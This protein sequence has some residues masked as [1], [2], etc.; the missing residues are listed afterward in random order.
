MK[1][2]IAVRQEKISKATLSFGKFT[3]NGLQR[4]LVKQ[5]VS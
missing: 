5:R 4:L 2:N 3:A 1:R